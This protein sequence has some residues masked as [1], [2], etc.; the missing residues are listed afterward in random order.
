MHVGSV[1]VFEPP[2]DGFD[3]DRLVQLISHADRVR[4][5]LPAADPVDPR[6]AGQ[7]GLGRRRGLRRDLP[8]AP[9]GAAAAGHATS[10]CR[11]SSPGSSRGR[12]TGT[13]RCGRSTSSRGW[14]TDRFAIVTKS[15]QALVDG[16]NAVDIAQVIVDNDPAAEGL[17]TDTWRPSHEPSDIEL[18]TGAL[19][20]AVRRPSEVVE[21]VRGGLVDL[22]AVGGRAL[23]AAGDVAST[24]GPHGAAGAGLA[25]QRRDRRGPPLRHG[26][27]RPR[28][29]P[30][31]AQPARPAATTPTTSPSTTSSS[32]RSSGAFRSLAAD[33]RR[34]GPLGDDGA[35]HG[36]GERLRRRPADPARQPA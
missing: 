25:P 1:M 33:P 36:A 3:Y 22:K 11:S 28:R 5:P 16:V 14:R 12:S 29:L 26:R 10:S 7:P 30:Q 24:A 6:A 18:L 20:D 23:A 13:A 32:P 17:I 9:L 31:G 34:G 2:D 21:N 35:R 4:A 27:H 15:H 19:V 8:R